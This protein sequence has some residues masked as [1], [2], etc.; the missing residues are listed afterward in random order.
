MELLSGLTTDELANG[1]CLRAGRISAAEAEP[2][3][4]IAEFDRRE[5]WAG[6][7][8]LSCAHWLSWRTGL[9]PGAAREQVRVARRLEDLPELARAFAAGRVSYSKVRAITRVAEPDDGRDWVALARHSTAAQLE[10]LVRGV[11]RAQA[12]QAAEAD[13]EAAVWSLRTRIRWDDQGNFAF[14]VSGPAELLPVIQAGI[15][16]KKAELQRQRDAEAAAC[17]QPGQPGQPDQPEPAGVSAETPQAVQEEVADALVAVDEPG[18]DEPGLDEPGLDEPGLDEPAQGWPGGTTRRD[19]REAMAGFLLSQDRL[20][21]TETQPAEQLAERVSTSDAEAPPRLADA[22]GVAAGV[23]AETPDPAK[24]TDAE[25]L[26]ALAQEALAAE[27]AAHPDVARRRRPQLTVQIDPLSGWA[28]LV[29]GELLPPSSLRAVMKTLPGR[30]GVLRLRPVAPADLRR[31]D[32]GRTA[33]EANAALRELL[34]AVDGERCRFPGCTR[35]RRLHAHHVRYWADGGATDLDNLVLVCARHH[36]L[37]HSQG[38][39]LV[40]H[41]DRRLEVHS[42]DGV[43]VLHHPAQPWGDPAELADGCR[44]LV[45][46]ETLPPDHVDARIDLDYAVSV[47]MAQAC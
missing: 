5:G 37:I 31:H 11:R 19:V 14:T 18:L 21:E 38:F 25:A 24:V 6:H 42:A 7:G 45:S 12:N 46:A 26:L 16:A 4:W 15:E 47:L 9:S 29:D 1:I 40:L 2:L 3:G 35:H 10:K 33:R 22:A 44:E 30:G 13:P 43:P 28:R 27:Q 34:G 8:L 32:R 41:P 17:S 39:S 36:T 20:S 23:P